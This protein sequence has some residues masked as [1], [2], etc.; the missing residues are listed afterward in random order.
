MLTEGLKRLL[1]SSRRYIDQTHA[2]DEPPAK[3][4]KHRDS[5]S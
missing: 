3:P 2:L 1:G 5:R 4:S